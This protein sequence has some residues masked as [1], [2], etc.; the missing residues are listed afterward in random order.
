MDFFSKC[1]Q[2]PRNLRIWSHLLK[3]SVMENYIFCAVKI[4]MIEDFPTFNILLA[5]PYDFP[6][7]SLL[8]NNDS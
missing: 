6:V 7:E 8:A 5:L 3:K 2:I 1:D 4:L